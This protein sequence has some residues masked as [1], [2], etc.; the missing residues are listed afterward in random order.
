MW[1]YMLWL[2]PVPLLCR[3]K[4]WA[5]VRKGNIQHQ[6]TCGWGDILF[7][8]PTAT[9]DIVMRKRRFRVIKRATSVCIL[10][11]P[12][13]PSSLRPWCPVSWGGLGPSS[14]SRKSKVQHRE[15][16]ATLFCQTELLLFPSSFC[17]FRLCL[18]GRPDEFSSP[19]IL[20][21]ILR[22]GILLDFD[23]WYLLA[24]VLVDIREK[25]FT[26]SADDVMQTAFG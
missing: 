21:C 25:S 9:I 14:W 24:L 10:P 17:S 12:L 13:P 1:M 19:L 18:L 2:R 6:N 3:A 20:S 11:L 26:F 4:V 5:V 16:T 23:D 7:L 8:T 22:C 15:I